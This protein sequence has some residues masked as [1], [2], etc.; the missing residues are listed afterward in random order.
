MSSTL[1]NN[2]TESASTDSHRIKSP[3]LVTFHSH[4]S[5]N[6]KPNQQFYVLSRYCLPIESTNHL[7]CRFMDR[8]CLFNKHKLS[9]EIPDLPNESLTV[10]NLFTRKTKQTCFDC[11]L[12]KCFNP[13]CSVN[14]SNDIIIPKIFHFCCYLQMINKISANSDISHLKVDRANVSRVFNDD[15][16]ERPI[17]DNVLKSVPE[18]ILPICSKRCYNAVKFNT[19]IDGNN[20]PVK[21]KKKDSELNWDN[22][23]GPNARSSEK[24]L[25]D[26][27]TDER[28]NRLYFGGT[29]TNGNTNGKTKKQYHKEIQDLIY[30]E[31]GTFV[32]IMFIVS[33][34][35]LLIFDPFFI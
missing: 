24:V 29:G 22:D 21:T 23:G 3:Q 26:W 5:H 4:T 14:G 30:K 8:F 17:V 9:V 33:I 32:I 35:I 18:I 31:N 6:D 25:V 16:I 2:T 11:R 10:T 27:L 7:S 13:K 34:N 28:N 1:P 19:N 20:T 15:S 12:I